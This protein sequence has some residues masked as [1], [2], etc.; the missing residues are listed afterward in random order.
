MP[1]S[2]RKWRPM[3]SI[4]GYIFRA[5]LFL[6]AVSPLTG[7]DTL[8]TYGPRVGI[9]LARF[10]YYFAEP[11][12]RGAEV[13]LDFEVASNVYPVLEAGFSTLSETV[14]GAAY[15]SSGPY[16]RVGIDYN[17]LAMRDRSVHHAATIGARYAASWFSQEADN[18]VIPSDYWGD[19]VI[20]SYQSSLFGHWVELVTGIRAEV[21]PNLFFG[22]S[23]R[24]RILL[25]P[26]MDPRV[27]PLL[28]PGYGRGTA[29]RGL[30]FTYAVAY[31]IPLLKK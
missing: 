8:R 19:Y 26:D 27:T 14:D 9:D 6:L 21:L 1:P 23:V 2:T 12:E 16:G 7:Q 20:D 31:K 11:A 15:S 13:S 5:I 22:W 3:K 28:V 18:I 17:L 10:I 24:Y 25:N 30:G 29:E 4:S